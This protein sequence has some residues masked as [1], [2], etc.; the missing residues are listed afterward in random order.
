MFRRES[1]TRA[2]KN[3]NSSSALRA[4]MTA[5]SSLKRLN[6]EI[7]KFS[8]ERDKFDNW[9][10]WRKILRPSLLSSEPRRHTLAISSQKKSG[11]IREVK[12]PNWL[13]HP[14]KPV[15]SSIW[16]EK[17]HSSEHSVCF[18]PE[19]HHPRR[20]N[21]SNLPFFS[22]KN[23]RKFK[24]LVAVAFFSGD[25]LGFLIDGFMMTSFFTPSL[26]AFTQ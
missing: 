13:W 2:S 15:S 3:E 5:M 12:M 17:C 14:L 25:C 23:R 4:P 20:E 22:W 24:Q 18:Q 1:I 21:L 8:H 7:W 16:A 10:G 6:R 26:P 9:N 11:L 19:M